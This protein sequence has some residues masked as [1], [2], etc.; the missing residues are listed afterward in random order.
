MF[1]NH[2][3]E[4]KSHSTWLSKRFFAHTPWQVLRKFCCVDLFAASVNQ[5]FVNQRGITHHCSYTYLFPGKEFTRFTWKL[6]QGNLWNWTRETC[7]SP[8]ISHTFGL[9]YVCHDNGRGNCSR[10]IKWIWKLHLKRNCCTR[11]KI[12]FVNWQKPK[13]GDFVWDSMEEWSDFAS[14]SRWVTMACALRERGMSY[15]VEDNRALWWWHVVDD[16]TRPSLGEL[17][18]N[19]LRLVH[20]SG[21][22]VLPVCGKKC[23][24]MEMTSLWG[25]S[26]HVSVNWKEHRKISVS[27]MEFLS[28]AGGIFWFLVLHHCKI[29][30]RTA[31]ICLTDAKILAV[32]FRDQCAVVGGGEEKWTRIAWLNKLTS[33][34][35]AKNKWPRL[36]DWATQTSENDISSVIVTWMWPQRTIKNN[37]F[38]YYT[39]LMMMERE[40]RNGQTCTET[41]V[42]ETPHSTNCAHQRFVSPS[43]NASMRLLLVRV[44][45]ICTHHLCSPFVSLRSISQVV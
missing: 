32:L 19:S 10:E 6:D 25:F 35:S 42:E 21:M 8:H 40:Y 43:A 11:T 44:K 37:L 22:T 38:R 24:G 12:P 30:G 39:P 14:A 7:E 17:S 16:Q 13:K 3:K 36:L 2:K 5:E 28:L 45:L 41:V 4:L 26:C 18:S 20:V 9:A 27:R 15:K 31:G 23:F 34:R 1:I 29:R 33:L